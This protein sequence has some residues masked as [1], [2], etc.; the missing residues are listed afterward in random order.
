[1]GNILAKRGETQEARNFYQEALILNGKNEEALRGLWNLERFSGNTDQ[2]R[3]YLNQALAARPDY[4][5]T[6]YDFGV[7]S[8]YNGNLE[9]AKD[10]FSQ[11]V[12]LAPQQQK[13]YNL[14]GA[15]FFEM[16]KYT[17]SE[18]MFESSL[19]IEPSYMAYTN[20][21]TLYFY[22]GRLLDAAEMARKALVLD[23]SGFDAWRTLAE[24]TYWTPGLR[25][26]SQTAFRKCAEILTEQLAASQVSGSAGH[27]ELRSDLATVQVRLGKLDE[28]RVLLSALEKEI[29]LEVPTMFNLASA[30][31]QMQ[32]REKA[33][34]WL[35]KAVA[36]DL[37]FK[38]VERY[39]GLRNLRTHPRFQA[40]R[41]E[42]GGG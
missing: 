38:Q 42:Y 21:S 10:L 34:L 36:A 22:S 3:E 15:T 5:G 33:L 16:D 2:A 41:R 11:L 7:F 31:E 28:A 32:N 6:I 8:Y 39:P 24:A 25:D 23:N 26:S 37:S 30:Y 17:D 4:F 35:E 40:L 27:P 19:A 20:L 9:L 18:Q 1:L 14:L 29:H 13:G 12:T